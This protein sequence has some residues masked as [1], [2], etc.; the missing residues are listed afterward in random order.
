METYYSITIVGPAGDYEELPYEYNHGQF[1][2][3]EER[4]CLACGVGGCE[5]DRECV[6]C[7]ST[8][9]SHHCE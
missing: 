2:E 4:T 6:N 8:D 5:C 7:G 1:D 9:S 3:I